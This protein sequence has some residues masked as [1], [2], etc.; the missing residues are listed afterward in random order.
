MPFLGVQVSTLLSQG[1]SEGDIVVGYQKRI[2]TGKLNPI[3]VVSL[4]GG[5]R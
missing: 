4:L 3:A 2:P 1:F 5:F